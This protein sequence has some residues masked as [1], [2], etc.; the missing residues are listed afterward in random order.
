MADGNGEATTAP[1]SPAG[2]QVATSTKLY[3]LSA[4]EGRHDE[5]QDGDQTPTL[6]RH[7]PSSLDSPFSYKAFSLPA[8]AHA[9]TK[10][11]ACYF[12]PHVR[13][14][15]G[16]LIGLVLMR[17]TLSVHVGRPACLL[18]PLRHVHTL[19][20]QPDCTVSLTGLSSAESEYTH[21]THTQTHTQTQ[22]Q[23][24]ARVLLLCLSV[25]CL[26]PRQL[27]GLIDCT[28]NR[29]ATDLCRFET[30]FSPDTGFMPS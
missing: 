5:M 20:V 3:H 19:Q 8:S 25:N 13:P 4:V 14:N 2:K 21:E 17:N 30:A 24:Q 7:R 28:E 15:L 29:L 16:P 27:V 12:I 10:A 6:R 1:S 23:A 9:W 26:K 22:A 11:E 18:V